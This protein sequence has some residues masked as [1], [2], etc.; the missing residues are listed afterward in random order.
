MAAGRKGKNGLIAGM[1]MCMCVLFSGCGQTPLLSQRE[2]VHAVFFQKDG[3]E[4]TALLLLADQPKEQEGETAG[5]KTAVGVGQTPAQA[6]E[7]AERSLDGQVFY[8]LMD[9]AVLPLEGD[10]QS[11]I[12]LGRLL[13]EKAQPAPQITLFLMENRPQ[14]EL[15]EEVAA[16]YEGM[17]NAINKYGLCNGLQLMFSAQNEC[18]LPVWQGT[19]YGFA[20]LQKDRPNTVLKDT[21][22]AQMA[23]VLCGQANRIDCCF[24]QGTAS[25]QG[26][27]MVQ[28]R[29]QEQG[30]AELYLTLDSPD[31]QELGITRRSE[32]QL[33][34]ILREELGQA[35]EQIT[36]DC[37]VPGFDPMRMGVWIWAARGQTEELPPLSLEVSF[38]L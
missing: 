23:A 8:G 15:T 34:Q 33:E 11:T 37:C 38:E 12:E 22:P 4:N 36:T 10:W 16:L 30:N 25:V 9:M 21:L 31:L 13:Y 32:E 7:Q 20:F 18:A 3:E 1:L 24:S 17:E 35:F 28:H 6:L 14:Q 19:E 27:A 2:I 26:K 5:Y 29:V